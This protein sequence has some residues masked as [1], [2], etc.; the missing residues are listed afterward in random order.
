[1]LSM[2]ETGGVYIPALLLRYYKAL[3]LSDTESMLLIHL[4]AFKEKE[5]VEFPT[6]EEIQARMS[7]EADGVIHSLQRLIHEGYLE[8]DEY[9][10]ATGV[11]S[12][13]YNLEPTRRKLIQLLLDMSE[14]E[15]NSAPGAEAGSSFGGLQVSAAANGTSS[16]GGT[17]V[18]GGKNIQSG[19]TV[20]E[21]KTDVFTMF[22][23]E[24]A[25]PITPMEYETITSWL[26]RDRYPLELIELALREA[27]FA[28]KLR[29]NYIDRIL[30][31]WSRNRVFTA[32][33]AKAYAQK[34][35]GR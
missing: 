34:F 27:V 33:Q 2:M 18:I 35:R 6:I 12:E 24:F 15:S 7:A 26:D 21:N 4:L 32:E 1:M 9:I 28:G 19:G 13:R 30:L 23:Q 31:E 29:F 11:Q 3:G 8:I 14:G 16:T 5:G 20:E 10:D 22:E 25:R 17:G